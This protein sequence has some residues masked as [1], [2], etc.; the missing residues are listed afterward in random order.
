MVA[1]LILALGI[2]AGLL[3]SVATI[4]MLEVKDRIEE[5]HIG[6]L[7]VTADIFWP[8]AYLFA[9]A[10]VVSAYNEA[11]AALRYNGA[12][13]FVLKHWD[14][15]LLGGHSVSGFAHAFIAMWPGSIPWMEFIYFG[16]F[17]QTGGCIAFLALTEGRSRTLQYVGTILI[18]FY[19]A[20][21][22]FYLWPATG[23][24]ASCTGHY[25]VVPNGPVIYHLQRYVLV[26]LERFR[27][28]L[29]L[30]GI[31]PD[32]YIALPSMHFAQTLIALWFLRK[33]KRLLNLLIA[34]DVLL[35][36]AILLL[37]NHYL[38][39]LIAAVPVAAL[40]I[41]ISG[42]DTRTSTAT[43]PPPR[44]LISA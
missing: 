1:I 40:A 35:V 17:A 21:V 32:Y 14:S 41:A 24:Y 4:V 38:V 7:K 18:A 10:I 36:P 8:T 11:I 19:I 16:T 29:P 5:N 30:S 23:P 20:L 6:L 12:A 43:N 22:F 37:E 28:G 2:R 3:A 34:F 26:A 9:G 33:W 27:S 15:V 44:T 31:R 39:D 25:S 13:E 42:R